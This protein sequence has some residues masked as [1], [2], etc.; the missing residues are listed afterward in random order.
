MAAIAPRLD[1]ERLT[2]IAERGEMTPERRALIA[3]RLRRNL[4]EYLSVA[5]GHGPLRDEI[6]PFMLARIEA[7]VAAVLRLLNRWR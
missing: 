7:A 5:G 3:R 6:T 2:K 4:R 1:L